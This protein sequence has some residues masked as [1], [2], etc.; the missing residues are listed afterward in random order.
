MRI[1]KYL[2]EQ[3]ILS[4]REAEEYIRRGLITLNG[5]VVR[6]MGVQIDPKKDKIEIVGRGLRDLP[7]KITVAINKP[8]DIVCSKVEGEAEG[9]TVFDIFPKFKRLN[10]VGRLD[11]DSEGLLLLS[12]DGTVTSAVTGSDHLIEKEYEVSVRED[13]NN[14]KARVMEEGIMLK[15]RKTLPTRVKILNPHKFV[16]ILKE[17]RKHQIRRMCAE[18]ELTVTGLKRIRIGN[19]HLGNLKI[20]GGRV[21]EQMEVNKLKRMATKK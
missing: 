10:V 2:S 16:I 9:R 11:K 13:I 19:I 21:L 5:K 18:M 15:G 7:E 8:R 6:E 3:K 4:R 12:N 17:G 14:S 20:G 1:Q